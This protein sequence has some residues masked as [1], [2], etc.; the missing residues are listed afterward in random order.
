[1]RPLKN[2]TMVNLLERQQVTMMHLEQGL[3][4]ALAGSPPMQVPPIRKLL[5][6]QDNQ[7]LERYGQEPPQVLMGLI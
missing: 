6:R 5:I 4:L 1:M 2:G 7:L 3:E